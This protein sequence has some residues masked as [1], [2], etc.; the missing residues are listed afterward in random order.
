MTKFNIDKLK[1]IAKP[2]SEKAKRLVEERKI[3]RQKDEKDTL[4]TQS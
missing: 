3:K 4:Q 2:R 1:E